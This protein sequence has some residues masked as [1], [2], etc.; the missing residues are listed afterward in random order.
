MTE[1]EYIEATESNQGY[2]LICREFTT[3][4]AEPDARNYECPICGND[5]VFGAEE[6][7]MIG[8]ITF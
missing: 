3:D 2:C 8:L 7:L 1:K 6:A 5:S 4:F